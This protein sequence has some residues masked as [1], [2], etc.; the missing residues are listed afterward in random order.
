[1][2]SLK[3]KRNIFPF[4]KVE[5][6]GLRILIGTA[7]MMMSVSILTAESY[8][9]RYGWQSFKNA[10]DAQSLSLGQT[11]T[12]AYSGAVSVL[13]NPAHSAH[14]FNQYIYAHQNRFSGLVNSD[15][16][17][18]PTLKR[19]RN[20]VN[21]LLFRE[22]VSHIPDTRNIL[23]DWGIDGIPGTGDPG[24]NNGQ[25]DEG[26]RLNADQV[27]YFRQSQWGIHLSTTWPIG[28]WN[29][30]LGIKGLFHSLG[31]H[32]ASGI[33]IDLGVTRSFWKGNKLGLVLTNA[34]TS[35]LVWENGTIERFSPKLYVGISQKIELKQLPI[36]FQL[37]VDVSLDP[38]GRSI[39]D[40]FDFNQMGGRYRTGL[41]IKYKKMSVRFG[42]GLNALTSAGLGMDWDL[43]GIHYSFTRPS[44]SLFLGDSHLISFNLDPKWLATQLEKVL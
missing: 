41:D 8:W 32:Y 4:F 24:E 7:L 27:H 19:F 11:Q 20:P 29:L 37:M 18:F 26:E 10:G 9:V 22:G 12:A 25:L 35:W 6:N 38:F 44:N 39:D 16:V 28:H 31:E 23:L 14:S 36:S 33:G 30:G 15:L 5:G 2:I 40:D 13:Q 43:I 17:A 42:R 3:V 34:S 1:M 21:V